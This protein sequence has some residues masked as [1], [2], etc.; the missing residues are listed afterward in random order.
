MSNI[1][2]QN[3]VSRRAFLTTGA[4]VGG[5]FLLNFSIPGFA[6]AKSGTSEAS[7]TLNAYIWILPNGETHIVNKNPECGQGIKTSFPMII[8]EEL[9]VAW[10]MEPPPSIMLMAVLELILLSLPADPESCTGAGV[11]SNLSD[12]SCDTGLNIL[13]VAVNA[14]SPDRLLPLVI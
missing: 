5:G 6:L 3:G 4:A 11:A 1:T 7:A 9:D 8:A 2:R 14:S 10:L 12:D 13:V